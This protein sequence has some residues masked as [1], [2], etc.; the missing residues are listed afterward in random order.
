MNVITISRE[1]GAGGGE[2]ARRLADELGW[3]MLDRQLLHQAAEVEHVPDADLERLDEKAL[4][5]VDRFRLHPPHQHY[6]HG[7]TE[8]VRTAAERGNVILVGRGTRQLLGE[9]PNACHLRLVAPRQ[10]RAARM[11]RLDGSSPEQALDRCLEVDRSRNRFTRY[12]FGPDTQLPAQYDLVVNTGRVSL[13][14]IA[15]C[16]IAMV[17]GE[18]TAGAGVASADR[19]LTLSREIGAGDTG[20]A[21]TLGDRLGLKVYD[22]ELLEQEAVRLGVAESELEKIDEQAPGIFQLFRTSSLYQLYREALEQIMN[23]LAGRGNI[24]LVGRGGSRFLREDPCAFHVRLVATTDIRVR[25]VMEYRWI[26]QDPA[27]HLIAQT[28]AKRRSFYARYFGADW[29]DPLEYHV[30]VNSGRL[31]PA[32][33]DLI[34]DIA[35]R[36]WLGRMR[37]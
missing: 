26:R 15:A 20:F 36:H 11:A 23:D 34:V 33:V 6:M 32:A 12:F 19:I 1:Y 27:R 8:A 18:T 37:D 28:D 22:R 5:M 17:R 21:P 10:W 31:G 29:A 13:E 4:S 25:R 14:D 30:T 35:Q 2:V 7:L 24:L 16:V 3:E 9:W